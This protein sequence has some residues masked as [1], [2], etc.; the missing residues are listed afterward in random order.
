MCLSKNS[1]DATTVICRHFGVCGGCS[2][3]HLSYPEQLASKEASLSNLLPVPVVSPLF[4][5]ADVDPET[6]RCFRQKVAFVFGSGPGGRGVVMGHYERGSHRIVPVEECPVHSARGNRIAFALRDHLV[7]AGVNPGLLRYLIIRT[8]QDDREAVA[9][10]VVT[11]N[12]KS[13]RR[14][15][16]ALLESDQRPDG[17]FININD[18]TGPFMV[19]D[20]TIRI[21][22]RS[23]VRENVGGLSYLISPDAFFQTNV[24]AAAVL[25]RCVVEGVTSSPPQLR[26]GGAKRRGGAGQQIYFLDQHHPYPSSAEEGSLRVLDLYCGGGLFSLPLAAAGARVI[27]IEDNRQAIKDAEANV[28]L[29]RIPN[30]QVR[31]ISARVEDGLAMIRREA[32]DAVIL[33]PPRQ[34]CP[35]PVLSAVFER[36]AP[37]RAVYVSCNPD[38]LALEL[39]VIQNA[40]YRI[41]QIQAVDM[42]PHTDHIETVVRLVRKNNW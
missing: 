30:R 35:K 18:N 16:R 34:G 15:V 12:D 14:P 38:A 4:V 22:G 5:P 33:D 9:M 42:F 13:L 25:Q 24:R 28:R 26:R 20:Q 40:G 36:I 23:H 19:G 11:R 29:N 6:P 31:F 8:T 21:E 1:K 7:R 37:P 10:L 32:W 41:E 17:F 39:P 2:L 27:G 3:Q